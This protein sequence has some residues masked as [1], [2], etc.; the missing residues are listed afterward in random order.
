MRVLAAMREDPAG[1]VVDPPP[2]Q[3]QQDP[4]A[5]A[6]LLTAQAKM[7]DVQN[8]AADSQTKAQQAGVDAQQKAEELQTEKDLRTLDVTK[9][10]IIHG[11]DKDKIA[12]ESRKDAMALQAKTQIENRKQAHAETMDHKAHGLEQMKAG[13]D[14]IDKVHGHHLDMAGH[15]LQAQSAATEDAVKVHQA[16]NPP[17][18]ATPAKPKGK[19]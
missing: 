10:L 17:K 12:M 1:L 6:K 19:K 15:A 13:V 14:A 16:L 18:P 8:K 5:Q 11:Q 2:Q 4:D 7:Q 3:P 9:E